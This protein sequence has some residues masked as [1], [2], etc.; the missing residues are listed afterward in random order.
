MHCGADENTFSCT[1]FSKESL[2]KAYFNHASRHSITRQR[3]RQTCVWPGKRRNFDQESTRAYKSH[4]PCTTEHRRR[5]NQYLQMCLAGLTDSVLQQH[6]QVRIVAGAGLSSCCKN[7]AANRWNTPEATLMLS[8]CASGR[9]RTCTNHATVLRYS[10]TRADQQVSRVTL[11]MVPLPPSNYLTD[12]NHKSAVHRQ[13]SR[14]ALVVPSHSAAFDSNGA[15]E[16]D[17]LANVADTRLLH[18]ASESAC[19]PLRL[20]HSRCCRFRLLPWPWYESC[21]ASGRQQQVARLLGVVTC[22]MGWSDAGSKPLS[23]RSRSHTRSTCARSCSSRAS[24]SGFSPCAP[25]ARAST[26]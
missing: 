12:Q 22:R 8:A 21:P 24:S 2:R 9:W 3:H 14:K 17:I 20:H 19:K 25:H 16:S 1:S 15:A 26:Q 5:I 10:W 23:L 4:V 7:R 18:D 13:A 11:T 6:S